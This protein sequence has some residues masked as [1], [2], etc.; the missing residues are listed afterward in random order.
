MS[1]L[2]LPKKLGIRPLAAR[3]LVYVLAFST[4]LSLA[5]TGIQMIGEFDRRHTD[6]GDSQRRAAEL[7]SA[8]L[9]N[10]LWLMNYAELQNNLQSLLAFAVIDHA[11]VSLLNGE[12]QYDAG[13]APEGRTISQQFPLT[14]SRAG[15]VAEQPLGTLTLTSSLERVYD[16]LRHQAFI[17]LLYQTIIVMLGTLG[18]LIIVRM[19]LSRHLEHVVDYA[20]RL[21]LDA[22]IEPLRL[23]RRRPRRPDELSELEHALN[24]MRLQLLEEAR[25]LRKT[26][27]KSRDERDEAVRANMAKN[28]FVGSVSH[29]L[30]TPLQSVLGYASLLAETTL[31]REQQDYVRTLQRSAEDISA[32]LNDLLDTSSME[33]GRLDLDPLPFDLRDTLDSVVLML[34]SRAREKGLELELRIDESLPE[35]LVGDPVRLRQVL[36]NLA[37]NAIKF[38]H[39]GHV[40]LSA[41]LLGRSR[42]DVHLRLSVE[43]TGVGIAEDDLQLIYEPYV[44]LG[45]GRRAAPGA[46]LGLTICRQ[47]VA[48][49]GGELTVESQPGQG[50]TFW[51]EL[52][53]PLAHEGNTRIRPDIRLIRD[54]RILVIDSYELSR[55]ITLEML[56]RMDV[57]IDA[58]RSGAEAMDHLQQAS[59]GGQPYDAVILDG[60]IADLDSEALCR[61][62]RADR[63]DPDTRI[64]L[65]SANPQRGDA[66]H[67]RQAG[68]DAFLSKSLRESCLA[69]MLQQLFE[70]RQQ[71]RRSFLTRFSLQP[72][73]QPAQEASRGNLVCGPL[74]VLLVEDNPVNRTLSQRL[75]EKLGCRVTTAEDGD[76]ALQC[77][78]DN[79]FDLI[80][81]DCL[82]P[83]MDGFE[84]TRKLRQWEQEQQRPATPVIALTASVMEQDEEKSRRSGMNGFVAKPVSLEML[85]A[86]LEQHCQQQPADRP[87]Q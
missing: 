41:E 63:S 44:Q 81:M 26:T 33:A 30:R 75:L 28:Q 10:N 14:F 27:L 71:G 17:T 57:R 24:T 12:E 22:L 58:A 80:F 21:N 39:S 51:L 48:L 11:Q 60:F 36:V 76:Q 85:Q 56:A 79:N 45:H 29:E 62:I 18:L 65:L 42:E 64:L 49:M 74:N 43:D 19:M 6:L 46:G 31:D 54:Q 73:R 9:G 78:Q 83:N 16:D 66:E 5:A 67:F 13:L 23:H 61:Q 59:D 72:P 35:R 8:N 34:A 47:L 7:M 53:L 70:D 15:Y 55:K 40:L 84:A 37:S 2:H 87:P 25:S 1:W 69:P 38:T 20:T 32:I 4:V 52:H 68:A 82:M 50:S 77:W 86:V 3:L